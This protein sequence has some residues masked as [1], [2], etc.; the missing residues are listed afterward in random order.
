MRILKTKKTIY[1]FIYFFF[2][3][4][5]ENAIGSTYYYIISLP[6]EMKVKKNMGGGK[7]LKLGGKQGSEFIF[8]FLF[9][10]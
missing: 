5:S 2:A 4:G 9:R 3:T 10:L 6:T 7:K 8:I 1:F